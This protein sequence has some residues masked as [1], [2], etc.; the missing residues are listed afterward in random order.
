MKLNRRSFI[1]TLG[2]AV[3]GLVVGKGGEAGAKATYRPLSVEMLK[4]A[5]EAMKQPQA[6]RGQLT[7]SDNEV[8]WSTLKSVNWCADDCRITNTSFFWDR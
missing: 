5:Q 6:I 2:A 1:K 8:V 4:E 7:T 3:A